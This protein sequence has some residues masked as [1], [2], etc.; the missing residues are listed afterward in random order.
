MDLKTQIKGELIKQ[1]EEEII[2]RKEANSKIEE[3]S[4]F[5]LGYF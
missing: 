3:L 5:I 4:V 1:K 2:K